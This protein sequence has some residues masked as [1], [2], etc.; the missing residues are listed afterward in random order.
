MKIYDE[1]TGVELTAPDLGAGYLYPDRRLVAH[2]DAVEEV[3]HLEPMPGTDGLRW[4]VVDTPASEAWDEY[5]ACLY[6]HPYTED[7]LAAMQPPSEPDTPAT[8]IWAEMAAAY[9]E[10]VNT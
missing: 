5:E 8:D 4:K 7:E 1:L 3:S 9:N 6:Y 2:H 10:G